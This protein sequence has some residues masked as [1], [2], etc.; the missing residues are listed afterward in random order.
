MKRSLIPEW[1]YFRWYT[2]NDDDNYNIN[3]DHNAN[4]YINDTTSSDVDN[5]N[6]LW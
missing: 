5:D 6:N 3:N 2:D 4:D 1:S